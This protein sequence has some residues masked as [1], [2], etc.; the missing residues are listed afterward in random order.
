[1]LL[2]QFVLFWPLSRLH[3]GCTM[4]ITAAAVAAIG[5]VHYTSAFVGPQF[6]R[7]EWS[8]KIQMQGNPDRDVPAWVGPISSAVAGLVFA[9]QT[10]GASTVD[11]PVS[12][13]FPVIEI[14]HGKALDVD[15]AWWLYE[16]VTHKDACSWQV[17]ALRGWSSLPLSAQFLEAASLCRIRNI[18]I[19][20]C[21][22]MGPP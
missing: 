6:G 4:K 18:L 22:R 5:Y 9:S 17:E 8:S 15:H 20:L 3:I 16:K 12:P 1:M 21:P 19:S 7:K 10:V 14:A 11:I 13:I 2:N